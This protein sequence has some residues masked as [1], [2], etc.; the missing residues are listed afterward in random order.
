MYWI[1]M[2]ANKLEKREKS[3]VVSL[4]MYKGAQFYEVCWLLKIIDN[5]SE[6]RDSWSTSTWFS[7]EGF[8][9]RNDFRF[10]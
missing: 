2:R 4:L 10:K 5:E 1:L 6:R 9:F 3:E 7:M 8:K